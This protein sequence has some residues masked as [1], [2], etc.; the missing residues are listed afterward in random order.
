[1]DGIEPGEGSMKRKYRLK[2][3]TEM[4][5]APYT[6]AQ[7]SFSISHIE[8]YCVWIDGWLPLSERAL[9]MSI[10]AVTARPASAES[11]HA[12]RTPRTIVPAGLHTRSP[13]YPSLTLGRLFLRK[14]FA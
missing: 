8:T 12:K 9:E 1:M 11:S 6:A 7:Y 14:F 2:L 5:S 10:L 13:F 3:E 4:G